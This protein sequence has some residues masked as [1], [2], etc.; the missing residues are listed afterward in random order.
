MKMQNSD[1]IIITVLI[2]MIVASLAAV[3]MFGETDKTSV[4]KCGQ[5]FVPTTMYNGKTISIVTQSRTVCR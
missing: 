3:I 5:A 2:V 4:G 1:Q